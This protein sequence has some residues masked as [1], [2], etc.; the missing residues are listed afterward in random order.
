MTS[1]DYLLHFML[2]MFLIVGVYQ[3]Y[4]WC[5]RR[6]LVPP[7][8]LK[9]PWDDCIP[10]R[11][12][13]VW[14][15]SGL[16]YPVILYLNAIIESSRAFVHVAGSYLLLLLLQM[17]FFL[18]VPVMTPHHWRQL[19]EGST[20]SEQ[21]LALVQRYDAPG[22]CFPSMHTSVAMLTAM[23]LHPSVGPLAYLFPTLIG[24]SCVFT[25]QHYLLDVPFGAVL[26]WVVFEA[27]AR[28]LAG[29]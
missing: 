10:F 11:P 15:Y 28:L 14:V 13:W 21:L 8:E 9:L 29:W 20:V 17:V 24:A 7:R 5:Q 1:V 27:Y 18:A 3:F 26:G 23:H 6:S 2:S 22:N 4:F 19:S 16:Y 25:K 12:H